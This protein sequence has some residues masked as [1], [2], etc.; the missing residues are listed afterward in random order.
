M[1]YGQRRFLNRIL[2]SQTD[3]VDLLAPE[4]QLMKMAWK[5]TFQLEQSLDLMAYYKVLE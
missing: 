2:K 3:T 5:Q 4:Q 1:D